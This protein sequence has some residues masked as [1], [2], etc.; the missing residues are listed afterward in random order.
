MP[1]KKINRLFSKLRNRHFFISDIIFL[2]ITPYLSLIVRYDWN[3]THVNINKSLLLVT[4]IFL[5]V[6]L[7]IFKFFG[8]YRR[9]WKNAS[10]DDLALL[11]LLGVIS[12]LVQIFIYGLLKGFEVLNFQE[13]PFSFPFLDAIMTFTFISMPRFGVRLFERAEQ[14]LN[15]HTK[16][17][18]R[19][20]R[21]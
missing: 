10:I 7:A 20:C 13:Y 11:T 16:K 6:K 17:E 19:R 14:R 21:C 4:F 18:I 8:L 15:N 3:F 9:Y 2:S 1:V 5:T 12:G